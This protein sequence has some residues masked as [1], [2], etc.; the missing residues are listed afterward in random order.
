MPTARE[1]KMEAERELQQR[2][3]AQQQGW[4]RRLDAAQS[5]KEQ[6]PDVGR[7]EQGWAEYSGV[8]T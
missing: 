5:Q 3:H 4:K 7:W 2:R 6:Q 8:S 1:W